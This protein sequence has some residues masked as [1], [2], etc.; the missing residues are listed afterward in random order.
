[1]EIDRSLRLTF[2]T[3]SCDWHDETYVDNDAAAK[4]SIG[5]KVVAWYWRSDVAWEAKLRAEIIHID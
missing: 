4:S 1:M 5:L 2:R 3:L